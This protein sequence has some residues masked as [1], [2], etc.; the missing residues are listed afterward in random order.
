MGEGHQVVALIAEECLID[1][2][3]SGIHE[4]PGDDVDISD[5]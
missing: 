2:A 3:K 5:A 1:D 4:L